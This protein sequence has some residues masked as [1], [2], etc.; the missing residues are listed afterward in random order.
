MQTKNRRDS[1]ELVKDMKL[2][3]N[4]L[5]VHSK[6]TLQYMLSDNRWISLSTSPLKWAQCDT[7]SIEGTGGTLKEKVALLGFLAFRGMGVRISILHA[8]PQAWAQNNCSHQ[9]CNPGVV[10]W[11][12][13]SAFCVPLHRGHPVV[14]ATA[15]WFPLLTF[16]HPPPTTHQVYLL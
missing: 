16:S 15:H 1:P 5:P 12:C 4:V 13:G 3:I 14:Q 11:S 10:L 8:L 2:I 6:F 7:F 9:T